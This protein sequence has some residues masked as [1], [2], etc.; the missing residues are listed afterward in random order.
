MILI[1]VGTHEQPFDRLIKEVDRLVG[2]GKL[3]DVIAQIGYCTY[4]PKN[5]K[6]VFKFIEF[7]EMDKLFRKAKII[8]THAGIGS[9]LLAVRYGKPTIV[10]PRLREFGEHLTHH[11]LDV[12]RELA[13]D[14]KIIAVYDI[15]DLGKA[16]IKAKK[17]KTKPIEK[18]RVFNI[19][20][21]FLT[22]LN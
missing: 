15:K 13:N 8:I 12:T 16:V 7:Q 14:K 3:K 11:Q 1:T 17:W 20:K 4:Q 2:E 9:T 18:G 6:K 22:R 21:D 10:V 19:I 5:I